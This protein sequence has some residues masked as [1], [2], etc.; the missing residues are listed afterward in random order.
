MEA[1]QRHAELVI[2]QMGAHAV[3]TISSPGI[4]AV[5]SNIG[6]EGAEELPRE[7]AKSYRS[8]AARCIYLSS[9]RPDIQFAV[10]EA[11]REMSS[12]TKS[13]WAKLVRLAKYLRAHPRL[14][15]EFPLQLMPAVLDVYSD[16]NWGLCRRTRKS[17]SGGSMMWG[18]HTIKTW[19]KTQSIIAKSSGE[20]E[21]Y[22][23][24]KASTEAL[25]AIT[26]LEDIG[27]EVEARIHVDATAAK[28]ILE[29]QGVG[30]VRHIEMDTMWL[31]EQRARARLPLIKCPGTDNPAD[32]M[33]KYLS[34]PEIWKYVKRLSM[35]SR[36]GRA[37][38]AAQLHSAQ[39]ADPDR[40]VIVYPNGEKDADLWESRG[41]GGVWRRRHKKQRL[42]LFT[43][44]RV[45][46]GPPRNARLTYGRRTVGEYVD[47][48]KFTFEDEWSTSDAQ[49][50][51]LD[52]AWTGS[53]EFFQE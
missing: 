3:G 50:K 28:S 39:L 25:G 6:E 41:A 2:E 1:D 33:T 44:F 23:I 8:I 4:D 20:S 10:K 36:E 46:R 13:S 27:I 43:P 18:G 37:Q 19:S 7:E 14:V 22:A 49:H 31:Q 35:T 34:A 38:A 21:L 11:C 52:R 30:G 45:P 47:G 24:V 16:A 5:E 12:P 42:S 29:R 15:W 48:E 32:M 9:D 51:M 40:P 53:T 26:L 17:T